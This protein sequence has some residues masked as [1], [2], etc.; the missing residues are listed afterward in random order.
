[1]RRLAGSLSVPGQP[2]SSCCTR[3]CSIPASVLLCNSALSVAETWL[4]SPRM[5]SATLT[6]SGPK[7]MPGCSGAQPPTAA[8]WGSSKP[9][10]HAQRARWVGVGWVLRGEDLN[11]VGSNNCGLQHVWRFC[12]KN[13]MGS[14]GSCQTG[15][16]TMPP[17]CVAPPLP[18]L[19][20]CWCFIRSHGSM[21]P[22]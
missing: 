13:A 19:L 18:H 4:C 16:T 21:C 9:C 1:M 12:G 8:A 11:T 15:M 6:I 20:R 7:G 22:A 14:D 2:T 3:S 10:Q 5:A 17:W